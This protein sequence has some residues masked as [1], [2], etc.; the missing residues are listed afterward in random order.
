MSTPEQSPNH[1]APEL[2]RRLHARTIQPAMQLL[3]LHMLEESD[4]GIHMH[5]S[6]PE[7]LIES[8]SGLRSGGYA[9]QTPLQLKASIERGIMP[10]LAYGWTFVLDRRPPDEE[11]QPIPTQVYTAAFAAR[12]IP[13]ADT[14]HV[15]FMHDAGHVPSYQRMFG[16][17]EFGDLVQR[18]ASNAATDPE[19]CKR[20]ARAIDGLGDSAGSLESAR[21]YGFQLSRERMFIHGCRLGVQEGFRQLVELRNMVGE[22]VTTREHREV[23]RTFFLVFNI[24]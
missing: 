11:D 6:S 13:M 5:M 10:G 9:E 14:D 4:R 3:G 2:T 15:Y 22:P 7:Q 21:K 16:I 24:A 8:S 12:Q 23:M 17:K 19:L 18:A 1:Y 20:F